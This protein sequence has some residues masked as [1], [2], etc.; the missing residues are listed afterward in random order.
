MKDHSTLELAQTHTSVIIE[1]TI[2]IS[3]LL[4]GALLI[5][6]LGQQA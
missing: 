1:F 5:I 4:K 2:Q 3:M 6:M